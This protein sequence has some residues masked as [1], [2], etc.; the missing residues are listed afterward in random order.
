VLQAVFGGLADAWRK[1]LR[2]FYGVKSN[3]VMRLRALLARAELYL[4]G[5]ILI[6]F[7]S[8]LFLKSK[9]V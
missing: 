4:M 5:S 7:F 6:D 3:E 9:A 8:F 1:T 2:T